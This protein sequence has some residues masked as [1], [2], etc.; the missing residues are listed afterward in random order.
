MARA[1]PCVRRPALVV[2]ER[3]ARG[4]KTTRHDTY[5]AITAGGARRPAMRSS[6]TCDLNIVP[7]FSHGPD[8]PGRRDGRPR[9]GRCGT[10]VRPGH[11]RPSNRD[12]AARRVRPVHKVPLQE[13][14]TS[15]GTASGHPIRA[16]RIIRGA[17]LAPR[18]VLL[19]KVDAAEATKSPT[20]HRRGTEGASRGS[21]ARRSAQTQVMAACR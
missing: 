11:D 13:L 4:P 5:S 18:D 10:A 8:T 3:V 15:T 17:A 1:R 9:Q 6:S 14:A 19:L 7:S 21:T 12:A 16:C 20:G 2:A